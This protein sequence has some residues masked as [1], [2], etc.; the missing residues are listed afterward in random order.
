M[1][2]NNKKKKI[3]QLYRTMRKL[4]LKTKVD[5]YDEFNIEYK[6]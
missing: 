6:V 1:N 2:D 5:T 4:I 3:K